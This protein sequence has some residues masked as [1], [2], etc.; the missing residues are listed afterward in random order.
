MLVELSSLCSGG[1]RANFIHLLRSSIKHAGRSRN[2]HTWFFDTPMCWI[3][4]EESADRLSCQTILVIQEFNPE[5]TDS[6]CSEAVISIAHC[7]TG[8]SYFAMLPSDH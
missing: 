3:D 5:K 2:R 6:A 1:N 8:I 7:E 4:K